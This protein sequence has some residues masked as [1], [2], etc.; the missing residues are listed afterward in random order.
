MIDTKMHPSS[1]MVLESIVRF[2]REHDGVSPT[3]REIQADV[4]MSSTSVVQRSIEDLIDRGHITIMEGQARTIQVT[5]GSWHYKRNNE[6]S[7]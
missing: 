5:S 4:G 1:R 2:K 3:V 6:R 7:E